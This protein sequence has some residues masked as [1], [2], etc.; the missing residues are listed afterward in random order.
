MLIKIRNIR[1]LLAIGV[2][3]IGAL[4]GCNIVKTEKK[5]ATLLKTENASVD[6]LKAEVN[7]FARV[8]S[9]KAQMDLKFEDNSF[10]HFGS[11]EEYRSA[12]GEVVV[13]RPASILLKVRVPFIKS[14]VAQMASD[15]EHFQVAVLNAG[16]CS[17]CK[18]F[19]IGTNEAD[20]S[21]LQRNLSSGN[22]EISGDIRQNV[23]AF[24]NL[25]PQH[26]TDAMLVRPIDEV[27]YT[28]TV[29]TIFQIEEDE[30]AS[31]KSSLRKVNRGY[32]LLDEF[33]RNGTGSLKIARRF[34]F[35]RIGDIRLARQQIFDRAGEIE[36][37]IIY[38]AEGRLTDTG[39]FDRLPLQIIVTRPLEKYAMRLTY[40]VPE[41]VRIGTKYRPEAFVLQNSWGLEQVD[42]DKK[43]QEASAQKPVDPAP[44]NRNSVT[45]FQ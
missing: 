40:Q 30:T 42:L 11:K 44:S 39:E 1:L 43:L 36:S 26:F 20:Y 21:S 32:Y 45:R 24:A 37:D 34:W 25:R 33:A 5:T 4:S 28:Y 2:F 13:Q 6:E 29:S 23:N 10:A 8:D 9:M 41:N 22:G 19:V 18:R 27:I 15:G 16:S 17:N 38:G 3:S 35:D 31:K 12:D 7:R 14:D